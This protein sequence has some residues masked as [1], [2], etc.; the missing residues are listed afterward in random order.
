[1]QFRLSN[2]SMRDNMANKHTSLAAVPPT[3]FHIQVSVDINGNFAYKAD[4][5]PDARSIRPHYGD[6]ISWSVK[7]MGHPV[8]FQIEFPGFGPFGFLNRAIHSVGNPTDPI[9]VTLPASYHGNLVMKYTVSLSNGWSDDPEVV[10]RPS[11]GKETNALGNQVILLSVENNALVIDKPN[12]SFAKGLVTWQWKDAPQD[13]FTLTFASPPPGWPVGHQGPGTQIAFDL[14]TPG[15]AQK[16][17]ID[18]VHLGLSAQG[19]LTIS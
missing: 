15:T 16:Y 2:Y 9:K 6:T 5:I 17:M 8:P 10:P 12:A 11:D 1:V 18:T 3:A 14:E 19:Q 13:Y 4:G 7:L